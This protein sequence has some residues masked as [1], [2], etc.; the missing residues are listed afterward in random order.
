MSDE[1]RVVLTAGNIRNHHFYLRGCEDLIPDGGLGGANSSAAGRLFAV[2][3]RPGPTVETDVDR[4]KMILR[5]RRAVRAF[6]EAS[7]ADAGD[8]VVLRRAEERLVE[9]RLEPKDG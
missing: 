4:T 8:L 9:V 2:R 7:A 3:F 1:R 5:D 6:L